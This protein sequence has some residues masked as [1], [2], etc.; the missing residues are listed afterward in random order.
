MCTIEGFATG[1]ALPPGAV[2]AMSAQGREC[3]TQSWA[4]ISVQTRWAVGYS[5]PSAGTLTACLLPQQHADS[6]ETT[7]L[8]IRAAL[9]WPPSLAGGAACLPLKAARHA[10]H[11]GRR[12]MF[13]A[14]YWLRRP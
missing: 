6:L 10:Y 5:V 12:G 8:H 11:S 9:T 3:K 14:N 1:H 7:T 13:T 4:F 2:G